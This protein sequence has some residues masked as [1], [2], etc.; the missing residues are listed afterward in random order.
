MSAAGLGGGRMGRWGGAAHGG[1]IPPPFTLPADGEAADEGQDDLKERFIAFRGRVSESP[2]CVNTL[3]NPTRHELPDL[4]GGGGHRCAQLR[5]HVRMEPGEQGGFADTRPRAL[6]ARR[7]S[8]KFGGESGEKREIALLRREMRSFSQ[9][10][11]PSPPRKPPRLGLGPKCWGGRGGEKKGPPWHAEPAEPHPERLNLS[12]NRNRK[13]KNPQKDAE[14]PAALGGG[15][16]REGGARI[17][18]NPQIQSYE[19]LSPLP[20]DVC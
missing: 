20:S 2:S 11:P 4:R 18:Q 6:R 16:R 15:E 9:P 5:A 7:E 8:R 1:Q 14:N 10:N 13:E 12:N 17:K 19:R 3:L